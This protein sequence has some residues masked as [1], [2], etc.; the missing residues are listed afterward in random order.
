MCR[1]KDAGAGK[2][3]F[4]LAEL[5]VASTVMTI[6]MAG[7]YGAFNS[8]VRAWRRGRVGVLPD[9]QPRPR[10]HRT[11]IGGWAAAGKR[12]GPPQIQPANQ[13]PR[14]LARSLLAGTFCFFSDG[15]AIPDDGGTLRGVES[16]SGQVV[17]RAV[18]VAVVQC[19]G[20]CGW[21]E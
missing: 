21:P 8:S 15:R 3:G 14:R 16:G 17:P 13:L 20:A 6:V 2:R 7:V 5:L 19:G 1:E 11:G 4:T 18:A 9:A 12:R 10:D